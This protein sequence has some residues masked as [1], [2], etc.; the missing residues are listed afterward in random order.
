MAIRTNT[1]KQAICCIT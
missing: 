1:C